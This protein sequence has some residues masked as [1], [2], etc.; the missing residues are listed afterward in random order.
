VRHFVETCFAVWYLLFSIG[1]FT[2]L[3]QIAICYFSS[4]YYLIFC[5]RWWSSC[6]YACN[7]VFAV[8]DYCRAILDDGSHEVNKK[9]VIEE[10]VSESPESYTVRFREWEYI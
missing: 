10:R 5:R 2:F 6:L 4:T 3:S 8:N 9:F 1:E 7:L